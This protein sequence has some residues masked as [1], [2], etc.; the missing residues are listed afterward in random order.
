MSPRSFNLFY[1]NIIILLSCIKLI[2]F[3]SYHVFNSFFK[4]I[5]LSNFIKLIILTG[6]H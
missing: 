2:N 5:N 6:L 3:M 4:Y 1:L